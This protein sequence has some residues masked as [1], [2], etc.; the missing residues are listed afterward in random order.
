MPNLISGLR[1]VLVPVWVLVAESCRDA[2]AADLATATYRAWALTLL[3]IIGVSDVLD[4][5]LARRLNVTSRMGA[6][7]DA[8][9]DKLCQVVLVIFFAI[10]AEPAFAP[11][12]FWFLVLLLARDLLLGFGWLVLQGRVGKVDVIHR[13]HGKVSSVLLFVLLLVATANTAT[14][15]IAPAIWLITGIVVASTAAYVRTGVRQLRS[16]GGA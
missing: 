15:V 6:T 1:I 10:R 14:S 3:C 8:F 4:G 11:I 12:P 16:G 5:W 2:A 7:L 13:I 9:A